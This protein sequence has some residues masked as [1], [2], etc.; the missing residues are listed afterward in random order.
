MIILKIY[1]HLS[2]F[3][4][5]AFLLLSSFVFFVTISCKKSA[6]QP[7]YH[8]E[9]AAIAEK[10]MVVTAHPLATKVGVDILQDGGNA[11]DAAIGV[12]FALAVVYPIAGNIG[13][14]GFMISR[15][16]DG[17][18]S[19]LDYREK[20]PAAAYRDMYLDSLDNVIEGLSTNGHLAAGVPGSVDG[21]IKIF[22]KY[23]TLKDFKKLI[24]PSID[25][26][27]KG[28]KLTESQ[29]N[30]LNNKQEA[31]K[32]CN[33][34]LPVFVNDIPWKE[35]DLLIQDDLA[36]T[37]K[38][39]RD[40]GKAGFY[41]GETAELIV[42]EMQAGRGIMTKEDLK[43]YNAIWRNPVT[44]NFK[45]LKIISMPPPSS[46]GIALTQLLEMVE[47]F[48]LETWGFQSK[49]SV[50]LMV[51]AEKRVY[52]DR[53]QHLGDKDFYDVPMNVLM[54]DA[55]LN[56]RMENFN[57]DVATP[58]DSI[59]AGI[60]IPQ[61]SEQTTHFSIV[62]PQGNAVSITTTINSGYGSKT[63]VA[64]AGFLLNN[65]M[66]DFSSKPGTPN[67]YGLLGAEANAIEPG[68]RMLSSMT[69]T[70]VEKEGQLYMV[71][72]SPGGSTIITSVFQTILNVAVFGMNMSEAVSVPRFH[73]QW[74]PDEIRAEEGAIS[75]NDKKIL[76]TMGHHIKE[77][78]G[79]GRV[80]AILIRK[81]GKLEGGADPRGDDHAEGF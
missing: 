31:F 43:D 49:E 59:Q 69:P 53:A 56:A 8:I 58:S 23:S 7:I 10:A 52:A 48:P 21:M 64:G 60:I 57:P 81:D 75:E 11:Y 14:G 24:Q 50:H 77:S 68:K 79:I 74:K 66:D 54:N 34:S 5:K 12:Q 67:F 65:E 63:V 30:N 51:E 38:R 22:E 19:A 26:A 76:I 42:K 55:Y 1:N 41:E 36:N 35:G 45:D 28:F 73:H 47:P 40:Q 71:V 3:K 4:G 62:D 33:T 80:D 61:E 20:A 15:S 78:G 44:T 37:L 13:G 9:K 6:P 70:I 39:I 72:G 29:A 25:L 18:I 27:E 2:V 16:M 17:E 46:G 32:K